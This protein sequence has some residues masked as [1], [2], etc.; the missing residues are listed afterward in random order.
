MTTDDILANLGAQRTAGAKGRHRHR[1]DVPP[2]PAMRED[3]DWRMGCRCGTRQDPA[4]TRKGRNNRSRG[5]SIQRK[6][7]GQMDLENIPYNKPGHDGRSRGE[8]GLHVAEV[9]SGAQFSG[10]RHDLI[11]AIPAKGGQARWLVEVETP[12]PGRTARVLVT[13]VLS[14]WQDLFAGGGDDDA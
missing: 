9:K 7:L 13:T 5:L 14:D 3:D 8:N 11:T 4:A 2:S 10:K 6:V 1:W 12:G